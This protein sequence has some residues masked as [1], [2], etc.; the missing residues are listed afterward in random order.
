MTIIETIKH[1][2][3]TAKK[4]KVLVSDINAD[5]VLY[6]AD[7]ECKFEKTDVSLVIIDS[8]VR[9]GFKTISQ[10]STISG[11]GNYFGTFINDVEIKMIEH[12]FDD[13]KRTIVLEIYEIIE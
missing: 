7:D 12:I 5:I 9:I 4:I 6:T 10:S 8:Y 1:K 13:E 3:M 11:Y 2:S